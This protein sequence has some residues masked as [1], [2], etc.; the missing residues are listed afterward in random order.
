MFIIEDKIRQ[1]LRVLAWGKVA[2]CVFGALGSGACENPLEAVAWLFGKV[3]DEFEWGGVFEE[4]TF[5][6]SRSQGD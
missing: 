5:A 1:V 3:L 6:I 2:H 4:V